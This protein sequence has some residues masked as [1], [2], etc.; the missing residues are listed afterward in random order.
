MIWAL[1]VLVLVLSL[2]AFAWA[3][4]DDQKSRA[5]LRHTIEVNLSILKPELDRKSPLIESLTGD[6]RTEAD[7]LMSYCRRVV[8][9]VE[10]RIAT[11]NRGELGKLLGRVFA[12]MNSSTDIHGIL[13]RNSLA[14]SPSDFLG[15]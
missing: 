6:D 4:H 15:D 14:P 2:A 5:V 1:A 10:P 8:S 3:R 9:E 7:R 12:A 13:A 11:A